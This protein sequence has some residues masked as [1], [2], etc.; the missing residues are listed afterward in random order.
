MSKKFR[1]HVL[2]VPHTRTNLD[3][4]ACAY[5]QKAYK[6]CKM[7][8]ERGHTVFHYGVEGSDPICTENV[9]VVSNE[10]YNRV[11]GE[12][13]F[14][15]KF[16][17]YDVS[18]ECYLTFYKNAI[19]EIRKRNRGNDII[20]PFWGAGVRPICDALRNECVVIEPGI[21]YGSGSWADYKVFESYAIYSAYCGTDSILHCCQN[22]YHV[23][24]QNYFDLADFNANFDNESRLVDDPYFLY[25]GRVYDGK[26]VHIAIQ[27]C[28]ELGVKLKI[29]GQLGDEYANYDWPDNVEFVGYADTE[30]R[31]NL[32]RNAVA[33]FLPS[34]YLEP[35]GGVQVENL[36][37]GTPTITS[38]WG[39]F[40]EN[41]IHGVTGYRCRTFNDYLLA[42]LNCLEGKINYNDCYEKGLE[43]TLESIAPKYE[44]FFEDVLNLY[45]GNGWYEQSDEVKVRIS[46][47]KLSHNIV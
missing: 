46:N 38:D 44:K 28:Q 8:T 5:T 4:V 32:M 45:T 34:Q 22:N 41:N 31:S 37:C 10:V 42:A 35:F 9:V 13:D 3:Y 16:F 1:I 39:A 11:Y 29:A 23:V 7:M 18:D 30:T 21:G 43:F 25:I 6:F 2:G 40:A 27:V 19:D 26:G 33:S 47:Y 14:H 36:L 20:L 12:H 17:R 15:S 24:I